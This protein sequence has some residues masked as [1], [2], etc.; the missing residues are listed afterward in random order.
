MDAWLFILYCMTK[1]IF[2]KDLISVGKFNSKL[3]GHP[4]HDKVKGVEISTGSLGHGLSIATGMA[5]A[6]K[7]KKKKN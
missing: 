7:I 3:G 4:E 5:I 1:T 2:L 6:S